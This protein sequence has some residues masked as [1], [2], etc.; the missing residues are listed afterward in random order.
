MNFSEIYT[1]IHFQM[2]RMNN[3]LAFNHKFDSW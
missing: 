3:F 1:G 2:I